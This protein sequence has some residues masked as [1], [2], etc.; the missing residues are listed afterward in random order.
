MSPSQSNYTKRLIEKLEQQIKVNG[1]DSPAAEELARL[2][3]SERGVTPE[4][5]APGETEKPVKKKEQ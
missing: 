2:L 1:K 4:N 5:A 3:D